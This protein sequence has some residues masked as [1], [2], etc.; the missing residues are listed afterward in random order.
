MIGS[1]YTIPTWQ[2]FAKATRIALPGIWK[3]LTLADG[4]GLSC[5]RIEN[6][7]SWAVDFTTTKPGSFTTSAYPVI[8]PETFEQDEIPQSLHSLR[9]S[10]R[11]MVLL[12]AY[13][14][15]VRFASQIDWPIDRTLSEPIGTAITQA[16]EAVKVHLDERGSSYGPGIFHK[17]IT[18]YVYSGLRPTDKSRPQAT[19]RNY[20]TPI[21]VA[22]TEWG[23][24][25]ETYFEAHDPLDCY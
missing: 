17:L 11:N 19:G 24:A 1:D 6:L 25:M 13:A 14:D 16:L 12:A 22:L 9:T 18:N 5:S 7:P 23:T 10:P 2:V 3:L 4:V 8:P 20:L 15:T 21:L